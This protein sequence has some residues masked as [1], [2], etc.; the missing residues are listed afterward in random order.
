MPN[1][2]LHLIFSPSYNT[3]LSLFG[4]N[5]PFALDRGEMVLKELSAEFHQEITYQ[6][7]RAATRS[8][9]LLVHSSE[10]LQSLELPQAWIEIFEL[11]SEEYNPNLAVKS[12]PQ[13][14][15]DILLKCGGTLLA[16]E[17]ALK[18]GMAANL[19]GGYH[20]AFPEQGRGFCVLH[21]IAIAIRVLQQKNSVRRVLIL[22]LDFHQGDGS[23]MIFRQDPDVFTFSVHSAEGWPEEKQESDM[24]ISI[25]QGEESLYQSKLEAG[26]QKTLST[27]APDL[28][29]FIA[30]SDPYELDVL[31][32]TKFLNLSL[33]QLRQ[34]DQFVIDLFAARNIP[35]AMV[36]A[37]GYGPAVWRVHYNAVRNLLLRTGVIFSTN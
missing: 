27:F 20:H 9:A 14:L 33:E 3:D 7:P 15:D 22:D 29:L 12:L 30:G 21:D 8:E 35:L 2:A 13:L 11:T 6:V 1:T 4:I 17:Q 10:Y 26:L 23:A 28:V 37:G 32:G 36:F 31:P 5:K 19:G 25:F 16:C 34:R 24:D 18:Y